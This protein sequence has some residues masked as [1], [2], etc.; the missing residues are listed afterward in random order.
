MITQQDRK[1]WLERGWVAFDTLLAEE[2][3]GRLAHWAGEVASGPEAGERRLHYYEATGQGASLC[4]T[5]RFLE[6][7][8]GLRALITDPELIGI[9]AALLGEPAVLY[10][11]KIN[12]KQPGGAGFAAHQDAT[13]YSFVN[14]HVTCLIAIDPMTPENGCLEF[15]GGRYEGL[16]E[17]DNRG[18]IRIDVAGAL[19]WEPVPLPAGGVVFFSS[20]APH[21]SGPNLSLRPRRAVYLTYNARAEGDLRDAYYA[22]R[23]RAMT[24]AQDA[25]GPGRPLR[26]STIGHF[27]GVP[28][29]PEDGTGVGT[30]FGPGV[31]PGVGP[32]GAP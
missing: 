28:A 18:C 32:G 25:A 19:S 31:G 8:D 9:A 29:R 30:E 5:E 16:L 13:A 7:H 14:H 20:L 22:E 17:T 6:D 4:R 11:E 21:R 15:A 27:Q 10:K 23:A 3:R 2:R 26:I 24:A 1:R 12:F